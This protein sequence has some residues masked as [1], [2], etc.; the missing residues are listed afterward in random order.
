MK[1]FLVI[2]ICVVMLF[3]SCS[4]RKIEIKIEG[5]DYL[6]D[7]IEAD[8]ITPYIYSFS[9]NLLLCEY[10]QSYDNNDFFTMAMVSPESGEILNKLTLYE[11]LGAYS[12]YLGD[13]TFA[14]KFNRYF[15]IYDKDFKEIKRY[16]YKNY[17]AAV[18]IDPDSETLYIFDRNRGIIKKSL[19][20]EEEKQLLSTTHL[21]YNYS[22]R[23]ENSVFYYKENGTDET[24]CAYLNL[25]TGKIFD[26]NISESYPLIETLENVTYVLNPNLT[27]SP[28]IIT[29]EK[30]SKLTVYDNVFLLK[31]SK[32]IGV[33]QTI[34]KP[35]LY[36]CETN[37]TPISQLSIPSRFKNGYIIDKVIDMIYMKEYDAYFF[38][39][40]YQNSSAH[41][42]KWQPEI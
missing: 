3:S 8:M 16:D 41:I 18:D 28:L 40:S 36:I 39:F 1:K 19:K 10:I 37:A 29:P 22:R 26:L 25:K 6:T 27:Y 31:D 13:S 5:A 32:Y 12:L 23:N 35:K 21:D 30:T 33:F 14:L 42:Y 4:L 20:T 34:T 2:L 15:A 7:L 38:V 9:G 24:K 17:Q 11:N